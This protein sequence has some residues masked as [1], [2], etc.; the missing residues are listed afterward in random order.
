[1]NKW[2]YMHHGAYESWMNDL[3][4]MLFRSDRLPTRVWQ[5]ITNHGEIIGEHRCLTLAMHAAE[6]ADILDDYTGLCA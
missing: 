2:H 6:Q 5:V 4:W 3:G 1:M